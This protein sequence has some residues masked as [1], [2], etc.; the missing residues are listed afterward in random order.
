MH[1]LR[2]TSA[3]TY[4]LSIAFTDLAT[5]KTPRNDTYQP[6]PAQPSDK[7][8][9]LIKELLSRW[10]PARLQLPP[11]NFLRAALSRSPINSKAAPIVRRNLT[12]R[13]LL[14]TT[15][16]EFIGIISKTPISCPPPQLTNSPLF[17]TSSTFPRASTN[18]LL[19]I[20]KTHVKSKLANMELTK[21]PLLILLHLLPRFA[22]TQST[23]TVQVGFQG[24]QFLP[25]T[26]YAGVNSKVEF[27]FVAPNHNVV[28]G[29]Y[30][31]ACQPSGN[32]SFYSGPS[33]AVVSFFLPPA[34][35]SSR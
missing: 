3:A 1:V 35:E 13:G 18:I 21:L 22:L 34:T 7:Q 29:S 30:S 20:S 33:M 9:P 2:G 14:S 32:S 16:A 27:Q 8:A 19:R 5:I 10:K 23:Q 31:R 26:I 6:S 24:L 12:Q 25:N 28:Q 17:A 4:L 11:C 15:G